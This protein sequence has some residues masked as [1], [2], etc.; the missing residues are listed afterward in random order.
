MER[1]ILKLLLPS[2]PLFVL[3]LYFIIS[4]GIK[5]S[6]FST[7]QL[8]T[9]NFCYFNQNRKIEKEMREEESR[10][11]RRIKVYQLALPCST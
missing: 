1:T 3:L 10:K 8:I 6:F 5:I 11:E 7:F 4:S 9:D 2:S